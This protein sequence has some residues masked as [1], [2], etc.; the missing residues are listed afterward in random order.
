MGTCDTHCQCTLFHQDAI[1]RTQTAMKSDQEYRKL[2]ELYAVFS[3]LTRIKILDAVSS[4]KHCV[5]DLAHM[6]NVSKSAISH[7]MKKLKKLKL[8]SSEKKGK[9]VYYF[10]KNTFSNRLVQLGIDHLK[11]ASYD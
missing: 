2:N 7:Q 8:V 5:C 3:D 11:G 4:E 1:K 10:A 6:L 9:M